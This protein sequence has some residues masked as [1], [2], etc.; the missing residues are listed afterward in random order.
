MRFLIFLIL[1]LCKFLPSQ[2]LVT[3]QILIF[4]SQCSSIIRFSF[5]NFPPNKGMN[6]FAH[7]AHIIWC[8]MIFSLW[9]YQLNNLFFLKRIMFT[10]FQWI[11]LFLCLFQPWPSFH[12]SS[13][14]KFNQ[15]WFCRFSVIDDM[16]IL[17]CNIIHIIFLLFHFKMCLHSPQI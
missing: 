7:V 4:W 8:L 2:S 6:D 11:F 14:P 12:D 9:H 5:I 16:Y 17:L 13:I 10:L 3:S 15:R 1:L